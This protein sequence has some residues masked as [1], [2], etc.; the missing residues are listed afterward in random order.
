MKQVV[1]TY[2]GAVRKKVL[3]IAVLA[4]STV[5]LAFI[6]IRIGSSNL[7]LQDILKTFIGQGTKQTDCI[8]YDIRLPRV[9]TAILVGAILATSGAVM[10]SILRNPL[11]SASTLGVSQGAA[12]GATIAIIAFGAGTQNTVSA[13]NAISISNPYLVTIIDF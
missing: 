5:I 13:V 3:M 10:Q 1:K 12:F 11:A 9:L 2:E 6:A 7:S 8:V 4:L